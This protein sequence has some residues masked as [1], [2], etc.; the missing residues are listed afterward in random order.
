MSPYVPIEPKEFG[1]PNKPKHK[2]TRGANWCGSLRAVFSQEHFTVFEILSIP[3]ERM[4]R[5]GVKSFRG[6]RGNC[7]G[8]A[9]GDLTE[10]FPPE[11]SATL[12]VKALPD[13]ALKLDLPLPGPL[14]QKVF[15]FLDPNGSGSISREERELSWS[16]FFRNAIVMRFAVQYVSNIFAG[17]VCHL[18]PL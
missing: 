18:T 7:L 5:M 16:W 14:I 3:K 13:V 12:A 2:T 17:K 15:R 8:S 6:K 9:F 1:S 4:Q 10:S 11:L